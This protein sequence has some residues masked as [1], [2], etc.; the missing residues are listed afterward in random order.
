MNGLPHFLCTQ[1][2]SANLSF[3]ILF[4]MP[5][6]KDERRKWVI[7]GPTFKGEKKR[8]KIIFKFTLKDYC[9]YKNFVTLFMSFWN[10]E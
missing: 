2:A 10:T 4:L 7:S 1:S 5:I 3:F 9:I 8:H 6:F